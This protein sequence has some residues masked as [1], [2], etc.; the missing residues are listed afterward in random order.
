MEELAELLDVDTTTIARWWRI[1]RTKAG[2]MMTALAKKLAQSPQLS[3][4]AS[5]SFKTSREEAR[6]ILE[7]I[8]RCRALFSQDFLFSGFA[9]VNIYDPYLLFV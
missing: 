7:L 5:G 6:K 1:F 9:W 8:N 2:V 3:D 4:W